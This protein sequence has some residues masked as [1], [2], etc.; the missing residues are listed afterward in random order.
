MGYN[1]GIGC[2]MWVFY[3]KFVN[4]YLIRYNILLENIDEYK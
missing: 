1:K 4:K 2:N 3:I